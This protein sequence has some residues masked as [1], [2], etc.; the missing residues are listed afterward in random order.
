MTEAKWCSCTN[1]QEML[2][3]LRESGR[4]SERKAR[5]FAAATFRRIWPLLGDER[6]RRAVEVAE[7]NADGTATTEEWIAAN[8]AAVQSF[9]PWQDAQG[10]VCRPASRR[11]AE[12]FAAAAAVAYCAVLDPA[13]P[14]LA[15]CGSRG[16]FMDH[17]ARAVGLAVAQATGDDAAGVAQTADCHLLRELFGSLPLRDIRFDPTWFT[18]NGSTVR[19]LAEAAYNERQLPAGTLDVARLAVLADALE[20]A[21]CHDAGL[22]GHLRSAGPHVRGCHVLDLLLGRQ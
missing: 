16:A 9:A 3:F 1:L 15:F 7:R 10:P 20:E 11:V 21:G 18:W 19:R 13:D 17:I 8:H 12:A 2:N 14:G 5:L 6:G 4:L 22:L